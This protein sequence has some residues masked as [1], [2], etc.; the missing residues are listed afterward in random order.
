M[1]AGSFILFQFTAALEPKTRIHVDYIGSSNSMSVYM[2]LFTSAQMCA[3]CSVSFRCNLINSCNL[4]F[5]IS[6]LV[7]IEEQICTSSEHVILLLIHISFTQIASFSRSLIYT[8]FLFRTAFCNS[9]LSP[10]QSCPSLLF[11]ISTSI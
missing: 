2:K 9:C 6:S 5:P 8:F 1:A 3:N 4:H 7:F 11:S 10:Q